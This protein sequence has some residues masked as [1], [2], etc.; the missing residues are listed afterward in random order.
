MIVIKLEYKH[1]QD[2]IA[3][4]LNIFFAYEWS[5]LLHNC[6]VGLLALP[7]LCVGED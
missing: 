6:N 5:I 3:S 4:L 2:C 1:H 7:T